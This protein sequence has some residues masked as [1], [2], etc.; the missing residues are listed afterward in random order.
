MLYITVG[1]PGSGKSTYSKRLRDLNYGVTILCPDEYRWELTGTW[2]HP[3]IEDQVWAQVKTTARVL[4]NT[5]HDVIID[6][7]ALTVHRRR[8]WIEIAKRCDQYITAMV[9]LVPKETIRERNRSEDR[10]E[11]GKEVSGDVL[12]RQF[13]QFTVP[14]LEE[15]FREIHIIGEN[16]DVV[17]IVDGCDMESCTRYREHA[18]SLYY[19]NN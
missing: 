8:E 11:R 18:N 2:W 12:R 15:G 14:T 9:F 10:L 16:N 7:T 6:A 4:L 3:P 1:V 13:S 19:V 5:G 17:E